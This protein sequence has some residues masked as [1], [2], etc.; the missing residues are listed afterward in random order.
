M[1]NTTNNPDYKTL[2]H[3]SLTQITHLQQNLSIQKSTIEHLLTQSKLTSQKYEDKILLLTQLLTQNQD[4]HLAEKYGLRESLKSLRE[5]LEYKEYQFQVMEHKWAQVDLIIAAYARYSPTLQDALDEI[6][7]LCDDVTSKRK[8][9]TVISENEDLRLQIHEMKS[10]ICELKSN[11]T[12]FDATQ[13]RE[14]E[15]DLLD[16]PLRSKPRSSKNII[17][18]N[19]KLA[20][21]RRMSNFLLPPESGNKLVSVGS[22]RYNGEV[23]VSTNGQ[24]EGLNSNPKRHRDELIIQVPNSFNGETEEEDFSFLNESSIKV[25]DLEDHSDEGSF[26]SDCSDFTPSSP[27][28]SNEIGGNLSSICSVEVAQ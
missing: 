5:A 18:K 13:E 24:T 28:F 15:G 17:P 19:E 2:Y 6:H 7:H 20:Q 21:P 22:S 3:E 11:M 26:S 9:S 4:E 27:S 1:I 8:I 23:S 16:Q 25:H 14:I 10:E 12:H